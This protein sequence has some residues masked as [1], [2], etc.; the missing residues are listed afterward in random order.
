[1]GLPGQVWVSYPL[2]QGLKH[3]VSGI[4]NGILIVWVSYPLKQGLKL[5]ASGISE[6]SPP[7]LSQ[8]SIKT[9]IETYDQNNRHRQ[10]IRVWVSYPLKQGLKLGCVWF[11]MLFNCSLSQLSIKTRIETPISAYN[12]GQCTCLS[13]LSI[14]T[15]IETRRT[16]DGCFPPCKFESA[17]H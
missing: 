8:L 17:I 9:R 2:K 14:K 13:Q 3:P 10:N 15:R 12:A 11:N 16:L 4:L 6:G 5:W 7:G 1:M